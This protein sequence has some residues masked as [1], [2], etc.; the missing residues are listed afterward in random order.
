MSN[1]DYLYTWNTYQAAWSDISSEE[2]KK[3]L[4]SSVAQDAIYSDPGSEC[5]GLDELS[6]RIEASQKKYPG[7]SFRNEKFLEHHQQG[8][9]S[10]KMHDAHG[11]LIAVGTS[12]ARFGSDGLLAQMTGFFELV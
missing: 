6:V 11:K 10:W 2:R 9:F 12:Y 4:H 8:L 7:A 3:L 5:H 1:Q